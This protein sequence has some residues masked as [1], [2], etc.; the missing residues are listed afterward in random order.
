MFLCV[1]SFPLLVPPLERLPVGRVEPIVQHIVQDGMFILLSPLALIIIIFLVPPPRQFQDGNV[2]EHGGIVG[3]RVAQV[4]HRQR[5]WE[6]E[7]EAV[8]E[9]EME[10]EMGE[11]DEEEDE[12]LIAARRAAAIQGEC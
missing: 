7:A 12:P 9:A 3:M 10:A 8:L 4:E 11:V 1:N 2:G 6:E 5:G